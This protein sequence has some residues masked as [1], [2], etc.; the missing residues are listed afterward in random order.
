VSANAQNVLSRTTIDSGDKSDIFI[1]GLK[2]P[3]IQSPPRLRVSRV[4]D[5]NLVARRSDRLAAKSVFRDPKP[6]N[7]AKRVMLGR[8]R[9]L[10][11]RLR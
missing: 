9:A 10:R 7:Q 11:G 2:V 8:R 6:E 1:A 5:E 3:L 4:R